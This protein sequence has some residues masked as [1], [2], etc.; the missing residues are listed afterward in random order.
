MSAWE[1]TNTIA[2]LLMPPG[3]LL[4][5]T[6]VGAMLLRRR[7][8]AG[9]ALLAACWM[10]LYALST[11]YVAQA[12]LRSLEPPYVHP[13]TAG[14]GD[15]IVVLGGGM[16]YGA[17]EYGGTDT[18]HPQ[19]LARLRYGARLHRLLD[20]PVLVTGGAPKGA[21]TPEATV[22][23]QVLEDEYGVPVRWAEA[24]SSNTSENARYSHRLVAGDGIKAIYL[25]T[26]AWHMRR[27]QASFAEAGFHVIPAPTLFR[28]PGPR[29][30]VDF[31]P[32]AEA[33][34]DS[35][36]YFHEVIGLAWYRMRFIVADWQSRNAQGAS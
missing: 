36:I 16:Y 15:A 7:R 25:V 31:L 35:S 19:V 27:A 23:K 28:T 4:V 22:M 6:A 29:T 34:E 24:A 18:L 5:L 20:R 33:L 1:I 30:I 9:I 21:G 10:A 8:V 11:P 26:H 17:P 3:C 2:L 13:A 12:L 32:S 14:T